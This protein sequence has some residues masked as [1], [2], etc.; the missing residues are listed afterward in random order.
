MS[1]L[2]REISDRLDVKNCLMTPGRQ[3]QLW[4]AQGHRVLRLDEMLEPRTYEPEE[5]VTRDSPEAVSVMVVRYE[6]IAEAGEDINPADSSYAKL[7]PVSAGDIVIS[8]IA[9]SH[10]SIAVVPDELDGCVVSSEYTVLTAK[11]GF[12]PIVLQLVPAITG[13]P[14]R[15][16]ALVLGCQPNPDPLGSD[17]GLSAPYPDQAVVADIRE[18][19]RQA[20]E[21]RREAAR[22]LEQSRAAL[23]DRLQL[24][25]DT[26]NLVLSAFKPPK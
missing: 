22:L 26:A 11:E 14:L 5:L 24:D 2:L 9:A 6:G 4:Q 13:D 8:N 23:H 15:H 3:E 20:D 16:P 25:T 21:A 7:Y 1:F 10:G 19:A 18:A 12:D 17:Q